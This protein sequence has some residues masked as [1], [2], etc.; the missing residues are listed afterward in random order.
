MKQLGAGGVSNDT[1]G[2]MRDFAFNA[3]GIE[4]HR[5]VLEIADG[6][7]AVTVFEVFEDG[8]GDGGD[9]DAFGGEEFQ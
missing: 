1:D 2:G 6:K 4:L 3:D 7:Q 8:G 5:G 9:A